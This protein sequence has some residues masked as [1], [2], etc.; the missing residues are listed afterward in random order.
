MSK[1]FFRKLI[2]VIPTV[3]TIS[4]LAFWVSISAPGNPVESSFDNSESGE[5]KT[6]S[7]SVIKRMKHDMGLDLPLF[8]FSIVSLQDYQL[9]SNEN[10]T[11]SWKNYVPF[12]SFHGLNNQYHRWL[13]GNGEDNYGVIRGD[14]GKSYS[15]QRSVAS[16]I[17]SALKWSVILAIIGVLIGYCLGIPFGIW[18]AKNFNRW[19]DVLSLRVILIFFS[20]P[21]FLFATLLLLV[22]SNPSILDWF[23]EGGVQD[24]SNFDNSWPL[25]EK[26]LHHIPY[27]ILPSI[28]YAYSIFAYVGKYMRNGTVSELG[29]DYILT[30]RAKGL[31]TNKVL[32]HAVRNAILPLITLFSNIFPAAIGGSLLIEIIYGIPGM[33]KL[34]Y[35]AMLMRDYPV[36]VAALTLYG[37]MTIIGYLVADFLYMLADPRIR[38]IKAETR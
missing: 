7:S 18:A 36:I 23:P 3:I 38:F 4:F 20:F 32:F 6:S 5:I 13:F 17:Y 24:T 29:L 37:L 14:F 30:A 12:I 19:Q 25:W 15:N 26:I 33:G 10:P 16:S 1:Y 9:K 21:S 35:D 11:T 28:A 2:I 22:F 27:L 31:K 8:Y 34:M